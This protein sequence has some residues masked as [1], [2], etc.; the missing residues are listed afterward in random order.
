MR[1]HE[2]CKEIIPENQYEIPDR[3][4][5]IIEILTNEFDISEKLAEKCFRHNNEG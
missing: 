2:L 1:A 5:K 4:N 3:N